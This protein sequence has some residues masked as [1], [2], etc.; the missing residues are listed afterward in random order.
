MQTTMN[1]EQNTIMADAEG[2]H[3]P[4]WNTSNMPPRTL[5]AARTPES[6]SGGKLNS[7]I[8]VAALARMKPRADWQIS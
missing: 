4:S 3:T 8:P 7:G 2:F 1:D 5:D 6:G